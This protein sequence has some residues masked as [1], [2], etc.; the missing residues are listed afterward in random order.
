MPRTIQAWLDQIST[1]SRGED[2][3]EA[4][5]ESIAMCYDDV[6][7]SVTL[8]SA[9][10]SR[11]SDAADEAEAAA[12]TIT[13]SGTGAL[14]RVNIAIANANTSAT[15][16]T[17]AA[18]QA[19]NAADSITNSSTGALAR[20]DAALA[21]VDSTLDDLVDAHAAHMDAIDEFNTVTEYIDDK[22]QEI[23]RI[24]SV[25]NNLN[26]S[27]AGMQEV[28]SAWGDNNSGIQK[29]INDAIST[30]ESAA[31]TITNG[32][33]QSLIDQYRN[34]SEGVLVVA[35]TLINNLNTANE[36]ADALLSPENDEGIKAAIADAYSAATS[37]RTAA[38]EATSTRSELI[39]LRDDPATGLTAT[40]AAANLVI[41]DGTE[42]QEELVNLRDSSDEHV[43]L[44]AARNACVAAASSANTARSNTD[45]ATQ[46]AN[47]A[48][49]ALTNM[50]V[51]AYN[52][53]TA[54]ATASLITE[55]NSSH[56]NME[57][58]LPKGQKGQD[59]VIKG[60]AFDTLVDLTEGVLNPN[61][62]DLY[63]VGT[64]PPYDVYRWTGLNWENQGPIGFRIENLTTD[65]VETL[66]TDG[67]SVAGESGKY[68]TGTSFDHFINGTGMLRDT[69]DGKVDAVSG[70]GLSDNNLTN[71]LLQSINSSATAVNELQYSKVNVDGTK[72]LSDQN[73][74]NALK[75]KLDGIE[76]QANKTVV[77]TSMSTSS[78]NPVRNSVVTTA[79]NGLE[80]NMFNMLA[81]AYDDT[82]THAVGEFRVYNK[83]L[84]KC[85]SAVSYV[86]NG[87]D[88][89]KWQEVQVSEMLGLGGISGT[90]PVAN[91]GTGLNSSPSLLV[92][93]TKTS[94]DT[95]LKASPRPGV[96]GILPVAN[97]G[98]GASSVDSTPTASSTKM[99]TSGGVKSA[100]DTKLN[101]SGGTMSGSIVSSPSTGVSWIAGAGGS[102]AGLYV[103][104]KT[105]N[106]NAMI[107]AVVVQTKTGGGWVMA[108]Y[109]DDSLLFAYGSK[110][111]IDANTNTVT[112][113]KFTSSGGVN[114]PGTIQQNG[115]N[116]SLNGHTHAAG[117]ITSGTF[118]AARIPSLDASKIGS[119]TFAAA[120]IPSLDAS[121]IGSGTLSVARG[122]T[123]LTASPSMLTN[124][125]TT[126][127]ANVLQASPRPGV[128]G[129]LPVANGGTGQTTLAAARNAM[130]L[131]NTTG[132]LPVANGG[133]GQTTLAAARNAMGLGNT[134]GALP[135]ANGGTGATSALAACASLNTP[136][137]HVF[138][139]S[140]K[141]N[142]TLT[143]SN[144]AAGFLV[145][146]ST[147]IARTG[148]FLICASANTVT[149]S[150]IINNTAPVTAS[151]SGPV[152][153]GG[154]A[155]VSVSGAVTNITNLT[156]SNLTY[157]TTSASNASTIKFVNSHAS[158]GLPFKFIWLSGADDVAYGS[159]KAN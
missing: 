104:K 46:R 16:A 20:V 37:A 69:L 100:L 2:V 115:T 97:G 95:I 90:V 4:I 133:T 8:A 145:I 136:Y 63:N 85:I 148:I 78:T 43:G 98:T 11:A 123:G 121:K 17:T 58:V 53:E 12:A 40:I 42:L 135:V 6:E 55:G 73:F 54:S 25:A 81:P 109:D 106:T 138:T 124:L 144:S 101:L 52:G 143:F 114:F 71:E 149:I 129:T 56:W 131:G 65:D 140:A 26:A 112:T 122:G 27:A 80:S 156:A 110:A 28:I 74:T 142:V 86:N 31:Q 116:V 139:L 120:R 64:E 93:L 118:D 159:I 117:N 18:T 60:D 36:V 32:A 35:D 146:T 7:N 59:F 127:A 99:V 147:T 150:P 113:I 34:G 134:T 30:A 154:T 21:N 107:P 66:W 57:F 51:Q 48:V 76:T 88:N 67:T 91:G 119:G 5:H 105:L 13:A 103:K 132:A 84:Y 50:T 61:E 94:A 130:G 24:S 19:N 39:S 29:D 152:T 22:I 72:V 125:G 14:A 41:S 92:D 96:S 68:I 82:V 108:N 62:G 153:S 45:A 155:N 70:K 87:F 151:G 9:E 33:T 1:A 83:K 75:T 102:G 79:F 158:A 137:M 141:S 49:S 44:I 77:D 10:I 128:T 15:Q 157:T 111:N 47:N 89:S 38:S 126:A 3:R 23:D